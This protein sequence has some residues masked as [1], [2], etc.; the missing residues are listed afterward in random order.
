MSDLA[1]AR[2]DS[3]A[4][5]QEAS[6]NMRQHLVFDA[7]RDLPHRPSSSLS[8]EGLRGVMRE[9]DNHGGMVVTHG[10]E[11]EAVVLS[12]SNYTA[13]ARMAQRE[14]AREAQQ[15]ADLRAHFDQR[16]AS[17]NGSQAHQALNAFLAQ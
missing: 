7:L 9:V 6:D 14:Q 15:L 4:H 8:E 2:P 17:L 5:Q 1:S 16:L 3:A 13:L 10:D 12:V 11:S